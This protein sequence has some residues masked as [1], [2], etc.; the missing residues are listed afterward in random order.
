MS[1]QTTGQPRIGPASSGECGARGQSCTGSRSS[2]PLRA[3]SAVDGH[4]RNLYGSTPALA[5]PGAPSRKSPPPVSQPPIHADRSELRRAGLKATLP[6]LK[7]LSI[8]EQHADR[9]LS[10]E[11]VYRALLAAGDEV[12]IATIYRVLTQF[13]AAGL[14]IRHNF[15]EGHAVFELDSGEHHDHIV[16]DDCGAIVEFMDTTIERR[17]LQ[18]A[19]RHGFTLRDHSLVLHGRCQRR[20]CEKREAS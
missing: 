9:H 10:A 14:V 17:Q 5:L 8:L 7:I 4:S 11:D 13:E 20:H 3:G 12:G 16:C 1:P 6:R 19:K 2:A 15:A 18:I